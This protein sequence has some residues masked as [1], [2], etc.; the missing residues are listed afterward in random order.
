MS[1]GA[2]AGTRRVQVPDA[3]RYFIPPHTLAALARARGGAQAV[4]L[5]RSG[6]LSKRKLLVRALHQA[7]VRRGG[8]DGL[9][10][11]YPRL[12]DLSRRDPEAWR[13]VMLHP[14]LDEGLARALVVL[15]RGER[16]EA[17]WLTWWERL[18]APSPGGDWPQVRA[19]CDGQVL[20]LRLA[21]SGPFRDAHGHTPDG[22]LTAELA[23]HWTKALSAAWKV[24]VRRHPWHVRAMAACLT[25]LAPLR[26]GSDGAAVSSAARRAYGAV[27][28]SLQDDPSLLALTLVHEFLHVQLGAL[29]DLLPLH[30]PPTGVR[31]HAPW[32]PD[33]RPA[34]ALLQG[35]YAHMGVTDFWRAERAVGGRRARREY[36]TWRGHTVDAAGTLLDSGELLPAGVRFVTE[37]R[38]AV[39]RPPVASGRFG[40]P[41]NRGT[42]AAELRA[43]GLRAGDTV[44]VHASLRALGPVTGGADTVVD[45]LRDVLGPAGTLVAYAQTPDNSDP[46]RWHLTRGYAV[47]E[48]HW[49]GLRARLPAFDPSRTPSFG[50]GVLPETVRTR[51]GALRS[52]HPQSSFVAL[53]SRARHVTEEHAPDC[54]LGE[55]S[56]LARLERLGA[57]VLLLGVGYDVC[58]AFHLAEYR[59]PGR[60]RLSYA[61]VVADEQGRRAWYHYDDVALDA[62][63]FAELGRAYEATGAVTRG[64]VGDADCRLLSLAP[65]VAHAVEWLGAR[66]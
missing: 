45:A 43:L 42:L 2:R 33:P 28:A 48:E 54:H 8:S 49:A 65:A 21:D 22:P 5:L 18:V 20:R 36:A 14:Y 34:G 3:G 40:K 11:V 50:V 52:A 25:T 63:P 1:G 19:E 38:D 4:T 55:H 31:Y 62:S 35:A 32:R 64:R 66:A 61:C 58:T 6:Q 56:P 29:L 41:R 17:E 39:R 30:G 12:L 10:A 37:L 7:A 15:E 24:I 13:T 59:V 44:V 23:R 57:R 51:P 46:A 9:D 27:G 53:G 16:I 47:P 26:P 60:P